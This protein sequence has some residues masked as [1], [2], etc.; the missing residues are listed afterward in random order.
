MRSQGKLPMIKIKSEHFRVHPGTNLQL[1]HVATLTEKPY[2]SKTHYQE[3]L[4]SHLAELTCCQELL[5]A[6]S[7]YAIL[8][9]FQAMD[10]AGKDG[11][12]R[13]VMSGINPQGCQVFSFQHPSDGELKHDFLWRNV[14]CLPERGRIGIFNRSYYEE[15][16]IVRVHPEI[17]H[18]EGVLETPE[19]EQQIWRDRFQSIANLERH[20]SRNGTRIIKFFLHISKEEQR[21]RLLE[22]FENPAKQWKL[23]RADLTERNF[24]SFYLKAY[25]ACISA[26]SSETAPWYVVPADDKETAR[27]IVSQTILDLFKK[28]RLTLPPADKARKEELRALRDELLAESPKL[29]T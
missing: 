18:S 8:L 27:L 9:I 4:Q 23:R 14:N 12:I 3:L 16:L 28:L 10:A 7:R 20:L 2:R 19:Q 1:D 17:L 13:H 21:Q 5:Y 24:W 6:S 26:T 29:R 15:V 22:R 11:V 25:D